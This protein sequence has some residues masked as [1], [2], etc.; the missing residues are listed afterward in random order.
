M[1]K[2]FSHRTFQICQNQGS[3]SSPLF[4]KNTVTFCNIW[5]FLP[6]NRAGWQVK[7]L[8]SNLTNPN[9]STSCKKYLVLTFSSFAAIDHNGRIRK[10]LTRIFE[11]GC[12]SW[13]RD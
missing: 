13:Y 11:F 4:R 12:F 2:N 9:A 7:G 6:G 10:M 8:E 3:I 1:G 5:L